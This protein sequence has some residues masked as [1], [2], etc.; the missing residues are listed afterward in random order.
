VISSADLEA[1]AGGA[2]QARCG[3]GDWEFFQEVNEVTG[4]GLLYI[5]RERK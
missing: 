3:E 4:R 5:G 2:N 1:A